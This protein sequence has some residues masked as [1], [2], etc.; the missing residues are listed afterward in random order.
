MRKADL[1]VDCPEST[2]LVTSEHNIAVVTVGQVHRDNAEDSLVLV[3]VPVQLQ[4]RIADMARPS[5]VNI[6]IEA[7]TGNWLDVFHSLIAPWALSAYQ[8][9]SGLRPVGRMAG[10]RCSRLLSDCRFDGATHQNFWF[11]RINDICI[12]DIDAP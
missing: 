12:F 11:G 8:A 10:F 9:L 6:H 7:F 3:G 4:N 1:H 5:P 2:D